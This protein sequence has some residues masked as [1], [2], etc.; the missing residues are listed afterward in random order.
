MTGDVEAHAPRAFVVD[1]E[2]RRCAVLANR[3]GAR[4]LLHVHKER[5][6][7]IPAFRRDFKLH[8]TKKS[9]NNISFA[10][11]KKKAMTKRAH[12]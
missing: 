11:H 12:C 9:K 8:A 5:R 4:A 10:N 3:A 1:A 7:E 6:A 2:L